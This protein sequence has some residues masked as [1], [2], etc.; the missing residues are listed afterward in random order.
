MY[1]HG[2]SIPHSIECLQHH[3]DVITPINM[4]DNT[5]YYEYCQ[6]QVYLL[7]WWLGLVL[8]SKCKGYWILI[9]ISTCRFMALVL[10]VILMVTDA[11]YSVM[12]LLAK[13]Y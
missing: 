9:I 1:Y 3:I 10:M 12:Y 4:T 2:H 8:W 11:V 6:I 13:I 5:Y 7:Y